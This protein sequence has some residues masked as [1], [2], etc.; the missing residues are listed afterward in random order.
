VSMT[1]ACADHVPY[2]YLQK[3][4]L[5]VRKGPPSSGAGAGVRWQTGIVG[6]PPANH[7]IGQTREIKAVFIFKNSKHQTLNPKP[8][9]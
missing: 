2:S 7:S 6:F 9:E 5:P 3:V 8:Y 4:A 1:W